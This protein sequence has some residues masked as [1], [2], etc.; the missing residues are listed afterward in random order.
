MDP[1]TLSREALV[2]QLLGSGP[3]QAPPHTGE[4][5]PAHWADDADR[6]QHL[7]AIARELLLRDL[8]RHWQDQPFMDAPET[9]KTWLRLQL[10]GLEHE[11]FL[12]VYLTPQ[13]RISGIE[14]LFRGSLCQ[15]SIYPR[16]VVKRALAVNCGAVAFVHNH[17][18]GSAEPSRADE[19][20]TA[21]LK[22]ALAMVDVRC[23]DHLIVAGDQVL[24]MAERGLV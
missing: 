4:A 1:T 11:E 9:L 8:R 2:A 3:C 6:L 21:T 23:V 12:V 19:C 20:L 14:R 13:H 22:N 15:A 5:L 16:E 17:P 24:S 18:S 7:L 10:G